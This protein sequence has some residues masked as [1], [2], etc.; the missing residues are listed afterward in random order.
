LRIDDVA[1][2]VGPADRRRLLDA[3]RELR[4]ILPEVESIARG[5]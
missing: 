1:V 3:E 5:A 4:R 2:A